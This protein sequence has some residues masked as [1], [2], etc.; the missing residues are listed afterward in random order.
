MQHVAIVGGGQGGQSLVKALKDNPRVTIVGV[1]DIN[2]QAPGYREAEKSGLKTFQ[3]YHE[4]IT[5]FPDVDVIIN[6]T[7]APGLDEEMAKLI[8]EK[9][10][11]IHG[12]AAM[13]IWAMTTAQQKL[14][15]EAESRIAVLKDLY[16]L[17]LKLSS[18]AD[19]KEA[20]STIIDYATML[21]KTPAGSISILDEQTGEMTLATAKGFSM[22]FFGLRRWTL[23]KGGLTS[24]ILN[25]EEPIVITELDGLGE[26][27]NPILK[28]EGVKSIIAAPLTVRG[29]IVGILYVDDFKPRTFTDDELS[30]LGLLT[31]YAALAIEKMKLLDDTRRMAIT[32]GLTGFQ[33]QQEFL[34][35]LEDEVIRAKRYDRPLSVVELDIDFF[36]K[37]NDSYGH[38]AGNEL[39][40]TLAAA[41]GE[42]SRLTDTC[43]RT[44][45]EEFAIIM[46]E[47]EF[48]E[49]VR[50]AERL[51]SL[52][53]ML[54][55]KNSE[56]ES[57]CITVSMGIASF[58]AHGKSGTELY[59]AVDKA[60][61]KAKDMGR[62]RV[63]GFPDILPSAVAQENISTS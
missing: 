48:E 13:F 49:A 53:E 44:G 4:L 5:S 16:E 35:R 21:T 31:G 9:T 29:K 12:K 7:N 36:K 28:R 1:C 50:L 51:R 6:V 15:K 54:R 63:I 59:Q 40:K 38:L 10:E 22:D 42:N 19:L 61:Y 45:G 34:T 27:I 46:P 32:D 17:G 56:D 24:Y 25:Q 52:I 18:S 14:N 3:D 23:R 8:G 60:L 11:I 20:Y 55:F 58:P 39:L 2:E 41:I 62:N 37:Y 26:P 43:A 57:T 33:N 30:I 47:T